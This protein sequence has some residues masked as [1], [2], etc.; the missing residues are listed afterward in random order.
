MSNNGDEEKR[1][2]EWGWITRW[3]WQVYT[4]L[5]F[6]Y[7]VSVMAAASEFERRFI[8]RLQQR[9]QSA[10]SYF[11]IASKGGRKER[12]HIHALLAV[13]SSQL[14]IAD[15]AGAWTGGIQK[16]SVYQEDRGAM[17]YVG[18]HLWIPDREVLLSCDIKM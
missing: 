5:T 2:R 11:A 14:R 16:A 9:T 7:A 3:P 13:R 18:R 15:V 1:E 4:T 12:A 17:S 6:R 10:V 8:Q